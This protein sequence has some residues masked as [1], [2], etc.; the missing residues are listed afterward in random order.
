MSRTQAITTDGGTNP[1]TRWP[2]H[3][4]DHHELVWVRRGTM[5]TRAEGR[6][7]TVP[8]GRGIWLPARTEHSGDVTAG[9]TLYGTLFAPD[10]TPGNFTVPAAV[11]VVTMTTVLESLLTHLGRDDLAPDAR[12]RAEAVVFD[13]LEPAERQLD[14]RVPTDPRISTVVDTLL[15]DPRDLRGLD[16][17]A[18][19][20]GI[21]ERTVTRAFREATGLTFGRWRMEL[22]IQRAIAMLSEGQTVQDVSRQLGYAQPSTF[23]AAFRRVTDTTPG[24][25]VSGTP[26]TVS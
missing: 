15:A 10:R 22:R 4:H 18:R 20:L 16:A 9:V 23:I 2:V 7:F 5:T 3:S 21:S 25:F 1:P 24:T 26:H 11:T 19:R 13:V 14:L 6:I 8:E 12:A 17:W